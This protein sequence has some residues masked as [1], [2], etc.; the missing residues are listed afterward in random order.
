[1]ILT[2]GIVYGFFYYIFPYIDLSI[3]KGE[4]VA[5]PLNCPVKVENNRCPTAP[6][7]SLR[8]TNYRPL[9]NRQEV[10]YWVDGMD[11]GRL[12]KCAVKDRKNWNC[13]FDDDSAQFG[14]NDGVYFNYI[15]KYMNNVTGIGE[16][17]FVSRGEWIKVSCNCSWFPKWIC[18]IIYPYLGS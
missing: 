7:F 4:I 5:Y 11:I 14:F 18:P 15:N 12:T 6:E 13:K 2:L 8:R 9:S 10:L 16:E 1:M 17:Y 3:L